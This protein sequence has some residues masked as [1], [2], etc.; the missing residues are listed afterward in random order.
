MASASVSPEEGPFGIFVKGFVGLQ[1]ASPRY[2]ISLVNR[3]GHVI[4]Q[5]DAA[6]R[7]TGGCGPIVPLPNLSAS[8]SRVYFLDGN[9]NVK[10]LAPNG[11]VATVMDLRISSSQEAVFAVSPDD[12]RI[13]VSVLDNLQ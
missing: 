7:R 10:S 8:M 2:T 6:N 4:T 13:A 1:S 12:R 5:V 9:S 11:V 3:A